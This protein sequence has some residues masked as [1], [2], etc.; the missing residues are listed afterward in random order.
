MRAPTRSSST[1]KTMGVVVLCPDVP[2]CVPAM[3][4]RLRRTITC[5]VV[6]RLGYGDL[7]LDRR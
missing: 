1:T 3:V 2:Q 7:H 6:R 4:A 5:E